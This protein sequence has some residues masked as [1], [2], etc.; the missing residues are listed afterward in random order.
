MMKNS[1]LSSSSKAI[2]NLPF[3]HRKKGRKICECVIMETKYRCTKATTKDCNVIISRHESIKPS[4]LMQSD[5]WTTS[6]A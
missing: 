3:D 4:S 6:R 2:Q 5:L 1:Y